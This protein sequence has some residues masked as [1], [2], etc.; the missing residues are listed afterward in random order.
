MIDDIIPLYH[1]DV[2]CKKNV[3]TVEQREDLKK[4]ILLTRE[5]DDS[6]IDGSNPGCW[7]STVTYQM[8][9]L[10]GAMRELVIDAN[11]VYFEKDPVFKHFITNSTNLD[12]SIWTNVNEVGSKNHLHSHKADAWAG[13][14]YI[15]SEGTGRLKF[16]NDANI[17]VEC[18]RKSPFTR[19]MEITPEDGIPVLAISAS[20]NLMRLN[21]RGIKNLV[22][23]ILRRIVFQ[24]VTTPL[25]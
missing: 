11:N 2:F 22:C 5:K 6:P 18:Q 15:Q 14:Y 21:F 12:F 9:W 24:N 20:L 4:Q 10:Y 23:I 19:S 25:L 16:Y 7:R 3:G 1:S 8:D 13:I 17:L